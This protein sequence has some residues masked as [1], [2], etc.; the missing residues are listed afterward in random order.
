MSERDRK[1]TCRG[2][3][4]TFWAD[5]PDCIC[6]NQGVP[7]KIK[8]H[9]PATWTTWQLLNSFVYSDREHKY[10]EQIKD[11]LEDRGISPDQIYEEIERILDRLQSESDEWC[12]SKLREVANG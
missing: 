7:K 12:K 4:R 10:Y 6:E 3:G 1:V 9:D 8:R 11:L 2:C 5:D